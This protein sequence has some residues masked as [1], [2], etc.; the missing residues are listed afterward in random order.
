MW[1]REKLQKTGGSFDPAQSISLVWARQG[2]AAVQ[3]FA[4][5]ELF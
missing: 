4:W 5:I 3:R 2:L 1:K